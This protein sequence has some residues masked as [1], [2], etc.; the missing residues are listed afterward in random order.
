MTDCVYFYFIFFLLYLALGKLSLMLLIN[1]Y[2]HWIT[3]MSRSN[4]QWPY[5][6]DGTVRGICMVWLMKWQDHWHI[7]NNLWIIIT[8]YLNIT[9]QQVIKNNSLF[10]THVQLFI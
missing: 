10:Y 4:F 2:K 6:L 9:C 5:T 1:Y 7:N 8:N 3:H